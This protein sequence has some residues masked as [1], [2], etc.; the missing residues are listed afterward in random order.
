[1]HINIKI[2]EVLS[3]DISINAESVD[4]AIQIVHN[5]YRKEEIV[6]DYAD[7]NGDVIIEQVDNNVNLGQT[8]E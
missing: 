1:M 2:T 8:F 5:M 7:F 6:L 3:R 4:E